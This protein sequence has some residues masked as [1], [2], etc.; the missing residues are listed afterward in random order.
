VP[1]RT[2]P[3]APPPPTQG[4]SL[5]SPVEIPDIY[6]I[7]GGSWDDGDAAYIRS[8]LDAACGDLGP[9]CVDFEVVVDT[10]PEFA[11]EVDC[12]ILEIRIPRP[13]YDAD[14]PGTPHRDDLITIAINDPCDGVI[15]TTPAPAP[16][17]APDPGSS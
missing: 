7:T 1:P 15:P 13:V 17:P 10:I 2:R 6:L 11:P 9:G 8:E 3:P 16:A 14:V 5:P 4:N 12:Q